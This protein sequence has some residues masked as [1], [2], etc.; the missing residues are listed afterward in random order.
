MMTGFSGEATHL[1]R[2]AV[3]LGYEMVVAVGGDGTVN[4]VVNGLY[5]DGAAVNDGPVLAILPLG[6][7]C[8][9]ARTLRI[10]GRLPEALKVLET[11]CT[12][13]VDVGRAEFLNLTGGTETRL[14]INIADLGGGGLVVQKANKAPRILGRRPNYL[15]GIVSAALSYKARAVEV[16]IDGGTAMELCVRNLIIANGRYFGRGFFPAPGAL[17]DDGL[18]DIVNVGNFGI[19]EGLRHVPK[20]RRGTHL[21]L[22]KVSFF[23]GRSVKATSEEEVLLEMDGELVGMLPASFEIIP[24]AVNLLVS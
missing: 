17:M 18:F 16:S 21:S 8:D 22:D 13:R 6:S 23:Q 1:A 3:K 4:E 2:E 5:Q 12:K 19:V 15:W 7:G 20:L 14:F 10:P 11:G 24:G 9:L